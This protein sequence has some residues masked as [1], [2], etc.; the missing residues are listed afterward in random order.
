MTIKISGVI[1]AGTMGNGI[2]FCRGK[3]SQ[4][5]RGQRL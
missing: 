2:G 5:I 4:A 1:G 3:D